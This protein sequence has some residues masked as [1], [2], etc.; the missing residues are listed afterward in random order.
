[1]E[2]FKLLGS[3][4]KFSTKNH[5]QTD[6]QTD[7]INALLEEYLRHYVTATQKNWVDLLDTAQLCYNLHRSSTTGM[8]PFELAMG[9]QLRTPL[10]VA[11]QWVRGDSLAAQRLAISRQEMFNEARESLEKAAMRMKKYVDQHRRA[12]EFQIGDKILLKLTSHILK[13][14]SSMTRQR[15]LIPK[16]EGPFEVIKKVGE[17]AYMLKLPE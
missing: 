7:W 8:S 12:L 6:D 4:L 16:F 5:P 9:W 15:G 13:K 17:V 3:K 1:M 10:D 2:L 11:K 14:V